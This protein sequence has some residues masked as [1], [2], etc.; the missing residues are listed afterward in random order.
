VDL[1]T[2]P[3]YAPFAYPANHFASTFQ[4][5]EAI[6]RERFPKSAKE[7]RDHTVQA[8]R[9]IEA[10]AQIDD[11]PEMELQFANAVLRR[12]DRPLRDS[13]A[14][15]LVSAGRVGEGFLGIPDF[16]R[17]VSST[18]EPRPRIRQARRRA[19]RCS[20]TSVPRFSGSYGSMF[21]AKPASTR[22]GCRTRSSKR[23]ATN[24]LS[25]RSTRC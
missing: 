9:M 11:L 13:I 23:W 5:A 21:C 7:K 16:A 8:K 6:A 12:N 4:V 25:T 19:C 24:A 14:D 20:P 18:Q 10:I 3:F 22:N 17:A 2:A 15:L 1:L